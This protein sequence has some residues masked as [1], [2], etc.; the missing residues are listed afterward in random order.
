[1]SDIRS[2][3][4][5][6]DIST[7]R[8]QVRASI[9]AAM[10][11]EGVVTAQAHVGESAV[12]RPSHYNIV[13]PLTRG[14][15]LAFNTITDAFAVWSDIDVANY[16]RLQREPVSLRA[17]ELGDFVSAGYLVPN[18]MDEVA[19][20]EQ[21]YMGVRFDPAQATMTVAP[22][23]ACNF[24][25][26]YCFQ[27]ADKP[28]TMMSTEVQDA[29]IAYLERKVESLKAL[30]IAWY[31]GEPLLGL[32]V[33]ESLSKRI[34]AL[35]KAKGVRYSAFIVT[36]G[37]ALDRDVAKRLQACLVQSCQITL[38]GPA[39]FHDQR[40]A[41]LSGKGTYGKI[42]DNIQGWINEVPIAVSTR[43]NI[44]ERNFASVLS[45]LEDLGARGLGHKRNFAIY[46]APV[47]AITEVCHGCSHV[48]MTKRSYAQYEVLLYRRAFEL[49]LAPLPK[50]PK[51]LGNCQAVH[52]SGLLLL[53]TGDVHKCW[54]T[55]H[56]ASHRVGT[57]FEP[58]RI[59]ESPRFKSWIAWSPFKNDTCRNCRILPNCAGA[60]AHKFVNR[61]VTLGE[62]GSLPCPSWKFNMVERLL[63]RAEKMNVIT[64]ED[65]V[66]GAGETSAEIVGRNHTF[67]SVGAYANVS[68]T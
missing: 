12:A 46:F 49:G 50:P 11:R 30:H 42:L 27:G 28:S 3:G 64:K 54:D 33:I 20:L 1:M 16:E 38:D 18:D 22:T 7:A 24:G 14:R 41:L 34:M 57:I 47:E 68:S 35:C 2:P 45:L 15:A 17:P 36:N 10:D 65:V 13:I 29:F 58:D 43:V 5:S 37:Y 23:M 26:D 39:E 44:D 59:P 61:H 8:A 21:R 55:V 48:Q 51:F 63:L 6:L 40:R 4:D 19:E 32:K 60:C 25:C 56:D 9:F 31:G 52:P 62:A 53:P 67:E 66:P